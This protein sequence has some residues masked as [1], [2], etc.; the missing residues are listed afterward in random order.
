MPLSE[1]DTYIAVSASSSDVQLQLPQPARSEG[2][3]R[4]E[5]GHT[6]RLVL[7]REIEDEKAT[8]QREGSVLYY[9]IL[10]V[11]RVFIDL[12]SFCSARIGVS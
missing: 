5:S 3:L 12:S 2:S 9:L 10:H 11:L 1:L 8:V 6:D 4:G 7:D